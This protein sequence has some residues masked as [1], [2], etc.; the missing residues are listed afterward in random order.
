[1]ALQVG[2]APGVPSKISPA[3]TPNSCGQ[4]VKMFLG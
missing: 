4:Q 3:P 1:M 2:G